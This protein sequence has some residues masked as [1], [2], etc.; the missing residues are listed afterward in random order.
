MA[1]VNFNGFSLT[2]FCIFVICHKN[3]FL[4][5]SCSGCEFA[6]ARLFNTRFYQ[7]NTNNETSSRGRSSGNKVS[8]RQLINVVGALSQLNVKQFWHIF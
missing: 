2:V 4:K 8:L 1:I 7:N 5:N 6:I 3:T